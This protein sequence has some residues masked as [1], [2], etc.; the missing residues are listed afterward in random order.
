MMI[1]SLNLDQ[2]DWMTMLRCRCRLDI[3]FVALTRQRHGHPTQWA[4]ARQFARAADIWMLVDR[5]PDPA[6]LFFFAVAEI[7][8]PG[9]FRIDR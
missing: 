5:Q 6:G 2:E 7:M 1:R 4:V 9:V 8:E 3:F